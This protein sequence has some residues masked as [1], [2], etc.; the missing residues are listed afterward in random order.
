MKS[1]VIISGFVIMNNHIHIIW[2]AKGNNS[3][4]KVQNSFIKH[5]SKEFKKLLEED[6]NLEAYK[7]NAFDR[8]Y[9]FWLRDSLKY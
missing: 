6:K 4:Q 1:N 7:V 8:K 3:L 2:Q 5:T 9:N